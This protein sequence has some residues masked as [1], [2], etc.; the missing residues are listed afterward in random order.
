MQFKPGILN[1]QGRVLIV[2]NK[3]LQS[4]YIQDETP[5]MKLREAVYQIDE[6]E[7]WIV[8]WHVAKYWIGACFLLDTY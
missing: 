4:S 8:D 3:R 7:E 2:P 5:R 1:I 6:C